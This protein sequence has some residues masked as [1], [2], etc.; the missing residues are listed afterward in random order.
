MY[1]AKYTPF[2]DEITPY[3][4]SKA[5]AFTAEEAEAN[6]MMQREVDGEAKFTS[7]AIASADAD[8]NM[9]SLVDDEKDKHKENGDPKHD[10]K[11]EDKSKPK[12]KATGRY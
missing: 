12:P 6:A 4:K 11:H 9:Q 5:A 7:A 10:G 8:A 1:N 3:G 2:A